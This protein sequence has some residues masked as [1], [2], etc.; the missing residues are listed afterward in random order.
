MTGLAGVAGE[1]GE[2]TD[3]QVIAES[4]DRPEMFA[5]LFDRHFAAVYRY[6]ARRVG[7]DLAEDLAAEVFLVA[8]RRRHC[9]QLAQPRA[10]PWLL[11]VATNLARQQWR[12]EARALRALA[13]SGL[14]PA[15][16]DH[17]D[18]VVARV[19]AQDWYRCAAAGLAGLSPGDRDVLLLIAWEGLSHEEVALALGISPGTVRSRLHRARRRVKAALD[20]MDSDGPA[21][22]DRHG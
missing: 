4:L 19:V 3:A 22:G 21:E 1:P 5:G 8:F 9:Y 17:A 12:A 7:T 13:R 10:L 11:G 2:Q 14:D 16:E 20:A 18:G 15:M 6:L